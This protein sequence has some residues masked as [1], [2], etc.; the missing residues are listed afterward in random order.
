MG[1]WST[2]RTCGTFWGVVEAGGGLSKIT[3]MVL[4]TAWLF[5][6]RLF[7]ELWSVCCWMTDDPEPSSHW[8][9]VFGNQGYR[10]WSWHQITAFTMTEQWSHRRKSQNITINDLWY[11]R[12]CESD[13]RITRRRILC[14]D[15]R[16]DVS[17]HDDVYAP[18][19]TEGLDN[20]FRRGSPSTVQIWG[21]YSVSFLNYHNT[22][23]SRMGIP[24]T[25]LSSQ[26]PDRNYEPKFLEHMI[27]EIARSSTLTNSAHRS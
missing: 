3:G 1:M 15:V 23:N 24:T 13:L 27:L 9:D 26:V 25:N 19:T 18:T 8:E 21:S 7:R 16:I 12:F 20:R 11:K 10:M 14:I 5:S 4:S 2:S 22:R 17:L 6:N